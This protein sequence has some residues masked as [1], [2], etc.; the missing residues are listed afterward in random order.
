MKGKMKMIDIRQQPTKQ[1]I[2]LN[3]E[4]IVSILAEVFD[5]TYEDID[6]Y[7]FEEDFG[8]SCAAIVENVE[9]D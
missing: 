4:D 1:R 9:A 8:Y 2:L 5:V 3:Y 6:L 7:G